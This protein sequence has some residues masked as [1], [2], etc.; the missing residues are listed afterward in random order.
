MTLGHSRRS[1]A[2]GLS[3]PC[4]FAIIPGFPG[5]RR[6][7]LREKRRPLCASRPPSLN[8]AARSVTPRY[9]PVYILGDTHTGRQVGRHV[10][11]E[12]TYLGYGREA[13]IPGYTPPRVW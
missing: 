3:V 12:Y 4:F 1:C 8:L 11:G 9:Q 6:F 2:R 10:H 5:R 13:Y 7:I